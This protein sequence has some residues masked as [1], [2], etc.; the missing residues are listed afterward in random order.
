MRARVREIRPAGNTPLTPDIMVLAVDPQLAWKVPAV[1]P[2][3][4]LKLSFDVSPD[5][6]GISM[7]IGGGPIL[8]REGKRQSLKRPTGF[9]IFP[10][11]YRSMLERHPRS[12][13]GWDDKAY[14]LVQVDGRQKT[15]SV[16]MTLK[17]LAGYMAKLGCKEV[18]SFDGGGSS[19]LWCNGRV[20]NRPC[21]LQERDVANSIVLVRQH[22]GAGSA[23]HS[24]LS[25]S[26]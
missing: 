24:R 5:L 4:V 19:E 14:Y 23:S 6:T 9:G 8:L 11:E 18:I 1:Q 22:P 12:A 2:G 16:G 20:V 10:Y 26:K 25:S 21:D 17:E 13:L 7:V 3:T 15:N